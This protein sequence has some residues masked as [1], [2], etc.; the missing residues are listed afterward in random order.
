M[1]KVNIETLKSLKKSL[2]ESNI[3]LAELYAS[4]NYNGETDIMATILENN[5]QIDLLTKRFK[6]DCSYE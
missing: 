4:P 2:V 5:K 3:V 6:I 1:Y